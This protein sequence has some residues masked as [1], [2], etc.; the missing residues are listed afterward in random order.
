M[1]GVKWWWD[2]QNVDKQVSD[3]DLGVIHPEK[4]K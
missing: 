1:L 4:T 3:L 2:T